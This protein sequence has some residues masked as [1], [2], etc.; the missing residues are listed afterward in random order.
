M[1]TSLV[2]LV[3][4][5]CVLLLVLFAAKK[6]LCGGGASGL[7][8]TVLVLGDIGAGKTVL[9]RKLLS[10]SVPRTRTSMKEVT[11][12]NVTL[13]CEEGGSGEGGGALN[14]VDFPG[15]PRLR[16][17]VA[18]RLA[19]ASVVLFVVDSSA[20][21]KANL[22]TCAEFLYDVMTDESVEARQPA[23]LI[24]CS[25]FDLSTAAAK[26]YVRAQ[27]EKE[28]SRLKETRPSLAAEGDDGGADTILLGRKGKDFTFAEDCPCETQFC[29]FTA[30]PVEGAGGGLREIEIFIRDF[31]Q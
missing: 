3:A 17:G 22:G 9:V 24:V 8:N 10:G 25:K 26:A 14:V 11:F 1:D 21:S 29:E 12:S 4:A 30:M 31:I 13:R 27:L 20:L 15:H 2:Y 16:S 18:A 19:Q 5:L 6:L 23:L 7:G 28:L